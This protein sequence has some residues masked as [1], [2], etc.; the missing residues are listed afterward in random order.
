MES[1]KTKRALP[2]SDP[3]STTKASPP[4][5]ESGPSYGSDTLQRIESRVRQ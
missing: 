1:E 3:L 4:A 5:A 2:S